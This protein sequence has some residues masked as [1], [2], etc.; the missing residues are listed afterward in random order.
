MATWTESSASTSPTISPQ[1]VYRI[2]ATAPFSAWTACPRA[3]EP[4]PAHQVDRE[5]RQEPGERGAQVA[6]IA[7]RTSR[8]WRAGRRPGGHTSGRRTGHAQPGG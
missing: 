8:R 5:R 3:N 2:A 7:M 6:S 1:M 4:P